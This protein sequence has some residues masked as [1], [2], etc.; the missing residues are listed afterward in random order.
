MENQT[1]K[2]NNIKV[3]VLI[4]LSLAVIFLV[5]DK[6][7][8]KSKTN[9]IIE[10]LEDT[11]TEKQNIS[12]ELQGL[13]IQYDDLKT[14]NDTLNKKLEIEKERIKAILE[15]LKYVKSSNAAKVKEYKKELGTLRQIMRSYIVQIDSLYSKNKELVTENIKVK[16]QYDDI[17]SENENLSYERD[18]LAGTVEKAATLK[19]LNLTATGL[20]VR[21]KETDRISKLDK[22]KICF[23]LDE[24]NITEQGE[25]WVYIRIAKPDKYVITESEYNLFYFEGKQIAYTA[26]RNVNYTGKSTDMCIFW[27]KNEDIKPGL[28]YV[29]I[30]TEGK[31]IGTLA[32][33]LK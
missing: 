16:N 1:E 24:N 19:A 25:K 28:Y 29:D 5:I 17:V 2:K 33:N 15:E 12:K 27:K 14:N 18:S 22:I 10:E 7:N 21:D 4:I 20:N 23:T 32:F 31:K 6:F 11:N 8:Q 30:F 9:T 3:I 26:K 13:V